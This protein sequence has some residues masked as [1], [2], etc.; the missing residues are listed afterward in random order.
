VSIYEP[1][2]ATSGQV[3]LGPGGFRWRR[4]QQRRRLLGAVSGTRVP[5]LG[6]R[7]RFTSAVGIKA[8]GVS[9]GSSLVNRSLGRGAH[10]T[11]PWA[12]LARWE[13]LLAAQGGG[14]GGG[15]DDEGSDNDDTDRGTQLKPPWQQRRW[16]SARAAGGGGG[17]RPKDLKRLGGSSRGSANGLSGPA[18]RGGGGGAGGSPR[19]RFP[20]MF[21]VV[22]EARQPNRWV[23][24]PR[25][26]CH[27]NTHEIAYRPNLD[28]TSGDGRSSG[29]KRGDGGGDDK[30][31]DKGRQRAKKRRALMEK[32]ADDYEYTLAESD[33]AGT[34]GSPRQ[35]L[36]MR[37][38]VSMGCLSRCRGHFRSA[39]FLS[40]RASFDPLGRRITCS[41]SLFA[42]F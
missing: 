9:E 1:R 10:Q 6:P 30:G 33:D 31:G 4:R 32:A 38:T 27:A 15:D 17:A 12:V 41:P 11:V 21:V 22:A 20:Y 42:R 16:L 35:G 19:P 39:M 36:V 3:P 29:G 25:K 8:E 18:G 28:G 2:N 24:G 34:R 26:L 23:G 14:G 40:V 5:I 7:A 37:A 13:Q